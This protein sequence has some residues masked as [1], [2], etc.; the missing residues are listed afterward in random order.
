MAP[1]TSLGSVEVQKDGRAQMW[2]SGQIQELVG[3]SELMISFEAGVWPSA[4][5]AA[6]SVRKP[7]KLSPADLEKFNPRQGDTVEVRIHST[8]HAPAAWE[9]AAVKNIK[10]GFYFMALSNGGAE[11][12]AI[13]EKDQLRP[14]T[15]HQGLAVESMTQE[16]FKLPPSLQSWVTTD[17]AIGC[18]SHIEDQSGLIHMQVLPAKPTL[19]LI[20]DPKALVRAKM[21]LEVHVKHQAQIQNFQDVREKRLKALE[22]KRNRIEGSGYK[23]SVEIQVDASFIPRIIGKGGEA[24]RALQDRWDVNVRIMDGDNPDDDRAIRIFGNNAENVEQARAEVE[25]VE[26]VLPL[27]ASMYS[28]ILGR[29]GKTIQGFRDSAGLVFAK[30][31]RDG[32]QLQLCGS[33]N[34]VQDAVAMFETHIMYYPVFHQMDEEMEQIFGELEE[35]GDWDARYE[36]GCYRDEEEDWQ[37]QGK[38]KGKGGDAGKRGPK[39]AQSRD[40]KIVESGKGEKGSKDKGRSEKGRKSDADSWRN[41]EARGIGKGAPEA[42]E[43]FRLPKAPKD[44]TSKGGTEQ[45][46][47]HATLRGAALHMH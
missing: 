11:A 46:S 34:S 28:W 35:Y 43:G 16:I 47:G 33:R 17:D 37:P 15:A 26:E 14:V 10:H 6:S 45:W 19:K 1:T 41:T 2:Y 29:G 12:E 9:L 38:G 40:R 27:D 25:F 30:L 21:L 24:I 18:F 36:W 20:G 32:E 3:S 42:T 23:H 7:P 44:S 31:D 13:V 5:Y 39:D 22:T 4:R 8:S